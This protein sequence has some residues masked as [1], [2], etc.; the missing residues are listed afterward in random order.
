[1]FAFDLQLF[2]N[3]PSGQL[4]SVMIGK[5]ATP[6]TAAT[7]TATLIC[8]DA[9]FDGTNATLARD[10]ATKTVG[11]NDPPVGMFEAKGSAKFE[12]DPDT[13]G[14]IAL[15]TLGSESFAPNANNPTA[16]TGSATTTSGAVSSG[17][18]VVPFTSATGY[19][20]G[21]GFRIDAGL[22]TQEDCIISTVTTNNVT[23]TNPL[24]YPHATGAAIAP[25]VLAYD[26]TFSLSSPRPSFTAQLNRVLEIKNAFGCKVSQLQLAMAANAILS[27]TLSAEYVNEALITPGTTPVYSNLF[28]VTFQASGHQV[29]IGGVVASSAVDSWS[30][31]VQTGVVPNYPKAGSG[32]FKNPN[33]PE[34]LTV[35]E[36]TLNMAYE[37]STQEKNFWGGSAATG[38]MG[39]VPS[40]PILLAANSPDYV[41]AAVQYG[42]QIAF[43]KGKILSAPVPQK[44]K[45]YLKQTIKIKAVN[46]TRGSND[47]ISMIVTN[48]T[49]AA[50]L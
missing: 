46:S 7:P 8:D 17:A 16:P 25:C 48:A 10:G 27:G 42:L 9:G 29:K 19:I 23:V 14:A 49:N 45:D 44:S 31:S 18:T 28:P 21:N 3:A 4:T 11:E 13:F 5:E 26:H 33:F 1:M 37:D 15:L 41:N 36:L 34:G 47:A 6:G 43:G 20:A 30:L 2:A 22:P 39:T 40:L 24:K 12:V 38:P 35:A 50:S 32:R